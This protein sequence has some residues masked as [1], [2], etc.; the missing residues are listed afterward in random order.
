[1]VHHARAVVGM[2]FFF[3]VFLYF[4]MGTAFSVAFLIAWS[5]EAFS[6]AHRIL[7]SGF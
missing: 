6:N 2:V 4:S 7:H 5:E 1:M 3:L